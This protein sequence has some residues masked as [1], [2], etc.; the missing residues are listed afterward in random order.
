MDIHKGI[1]ARFRMNKYSSYN[2]IKRHTLRF[3]QTVPEFVNGDFLITRYSFARYFNAFSFCRSCNF[4][5]P[6]FG[7]VHKTGSNRI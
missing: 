4:C 3:Y 6:Q 5:N 2:L 7:K 1:S